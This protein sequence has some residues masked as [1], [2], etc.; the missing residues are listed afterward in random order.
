MLTFIGLC[1]YDIDGAQKYPPVVQ[2]FTLEQ[3]E[4]AR[5]EADNSII[6]I[7]DSSNLKKKVYENIYELE[8]QINPETTDDL[9]RT[10]KLIDYDREPEGSI[11]S[12]AYQIS[13]STYYVKTWGGISGTEDGIKLP[14]ALEPDILCIVNGCNFSI[15]V[16]PFSGE[17]FDDLAVNGPKTLQSGKRFF[18]ACQKNGEWVVADDYGL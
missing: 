14:M 9:I 1:V 18:V 4:A 16:Y 6:T 7:R 11:Q 2:Y 17:K 13:N 5:L 10:L 3:I 15:K 8:S 12:T